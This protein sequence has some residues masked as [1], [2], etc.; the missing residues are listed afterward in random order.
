MCWRQLCFVFANKLLP[1]S[2]KVRL[3]L[4]GAA[5]IMGYCIH[6]LNVWMNFCVRL[7]FFQYFF[8]DNVM[9]QYIAIRIVID[10]HV[11]Q[12]YTIIDF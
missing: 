2:I 9:W 6:T 3:F 10:C 7:A 8:S 4:N 1:I 12:Y 11:L 5:R